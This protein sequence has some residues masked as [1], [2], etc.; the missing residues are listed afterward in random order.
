[1]KLLKVESEAG[2]YL[3]ENGDFAPIDK[4]TK[5]DVLRLVGL[6]LAEDTQTDEFDADLVKNQAHQ[7]IYKNLQQKLRDLS[8]RRQGFADQSQRVFLHAYEKY[9]KEPVQQGTLADGESS[10]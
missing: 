7:I 1:M 6:S 8:E 4:I 3:M 5:Q 2:W 9:Q 10:S